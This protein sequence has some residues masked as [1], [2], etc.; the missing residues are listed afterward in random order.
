ME[1]GIEINELRNKVNGKPDKKPIKLIRILDTNGLFSGNGFETSDVYDYVLIS[2]SHC[3][4][5]GY[6]VIAEIGTDISDNDVYLG[7]WNDGVIN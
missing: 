7:Y 3:M 5:E 2:A 1:Q 6:D 4:A